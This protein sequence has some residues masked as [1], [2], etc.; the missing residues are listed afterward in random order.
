NGEYLEKYTFTMTAVFDES[1]QTA[2]VTGTVEAE[3]G[4]RQPFGWPVPVDWSSVGPATLTGTFV[5][6]TNTLTATITNV[7]EPAS[8]S[9]LAMGGLLLA[10]RRR[11][12]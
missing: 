8:L 3:V 6:A 1:W 9:L 4:D 5:S 11:S 12:R 7:P 10:R 2:T